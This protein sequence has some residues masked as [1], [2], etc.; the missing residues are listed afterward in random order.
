MPHN[1][2]GDSGGL[3]GGVGQAWTQ[4]CSLL[5]PQR[6][7]CATGGK[8]PVKFSG[9]HNESFP[10]PCQSYHLQNRYIL[11]VYESGDHIAAGTSVRSKVG[12][13]SVTFHQSL[14]T[15][16][17]Y[18]F[19]GWRINHICEP[20]HRLCIQY[21][22]W[23]TN[24]VFHIFQELLCHYPVFLNFILGP[25][26]NPGLWRGARPLA[27]E[28]VPVQGHLKRAPT[29]MCIRWKRTVVPGRV[30]QEGQI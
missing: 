19:T 23:G 2:L 18:V 1:W 29:H 7:G 6:R 26:S 16:N 3:Q 4:C 8:E 12:L 27:L 25:G 17:N 20:G 15:K 21:K 13:S 22:Y 28:Q 10:Y 24:P 9:W 11:N 30:Q 5:Q 14:D